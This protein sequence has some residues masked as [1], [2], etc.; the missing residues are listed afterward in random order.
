MAADVIAFNSRFNL[1]SFLAKVDSHLRKAYLPVDNVSS[2]IRSKSHVLYYPL[3]IGTILALAESSTSDETA[4]D[5]PDASAVSSDSSA[6]VDRPAQCQEDKVI[7]ALCF[8]II[9]M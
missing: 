5:V 2:K 6:G 7:F 1:E 4:M 3:D 8:L 9:A